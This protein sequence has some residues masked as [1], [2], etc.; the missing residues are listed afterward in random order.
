MEIFFIFFGAIKLANA[1]YI[2]GSNKKE[3]FNLITISFW[4]LTFILVGA[5]EL[6]GVGGVLKSLAYLLFGLSWLPMMW[7]PCT[8]KIFRINKKSLF[9]RRAIFLIIGAAAIFMK[10]L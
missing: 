7:S 1:L 4:G 10:V 2:Y 3:I 6:I 8:D 5:V 9:I